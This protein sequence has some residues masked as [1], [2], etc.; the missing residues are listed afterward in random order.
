VAVQDCDLSGGQRD[1]VS[2][3][4]PIGLRVERNKLTGA[5]GTKA[6]PA[7]AGLH[8]EAADRGQPTL[9]VTVAHNL[10]TDNAGPGVFFDLDPAN[11]PPVLASELDVTANQV[12]RNARR[13]RAPKRGGIVVAGGQR[14]STGRMTLADNVVLGNRG[15]GLLG[16]K[17]R[18]LLD[19]HGN[20]V[21]GNSGG[22]MR[23]L[24]LYPAVGATTGARTLPPTS[25]PGSPRDDTTWLQARLDRAGGTIFL[26]KLPDGECYATR[27]LWVSHDDTT[28][29]SD[30]ACIVSLGLGPV[31]LRSNDGDPIASSAVFFVNRSRP[32]QPAPVGVTISNLE[33]I[34]PAGQGMFGVE[35]YGHQT[36]LSHVDISGAPKDDVLIS[37]RANGNAYSG[38]VAILDSVLSG[39]E[40]NAVSATG[41]I[42]LRIEGNVIQGV[43][44]LPPGQPAAGIDVE[45]DD[46]G[47]PARDVHI[48]RNTI[49]DNAGPGILLELES[50][51]GNALVATGLE[52]ADNT[53]V[54]NALKPFPP[55]KAGIVLAGGQ[56][57]GE[58]T[59]VLKRNVIRGNGGPGILASRLVLRVDAS[60]NVVG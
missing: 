30:G 3:F 50:N 44:D 26:P 59:L 33:I 51:E 29:T 8:I 55:K 14:D 60:D 19:L 7:A 54:R 43:R 21:R 48:L 40:R 49:Q 25:A 22:A 5:R 47:Q 20:D 18:L 23:G 2:A 13:A 34:V 15:P 32:T 31:R 42:D 4:G 36:T 38:R 28:I 9:D 41:V 37:G 52:I 53:I 57:G 27:G 10:I 56:D 45:P 12:L 1:V 35:V 6:A 11:G 46:R 58:G 16:R 17:L 39:A 24:R